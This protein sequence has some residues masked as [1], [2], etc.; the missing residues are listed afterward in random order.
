MMSM[1]DIM[2]GMLGITIMMLGIAI[3]IVISNLVIMSTLKMMMIIGV[4]GG[5][6]LDW[7]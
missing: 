4:D 7:G 2:V 5:C 1:L 3:A 6:A